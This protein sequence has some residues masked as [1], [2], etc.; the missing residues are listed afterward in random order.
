[1]ARYGVSKPLWLNE[2]SLGCP[3]FYAHCLPPTASFYQ[4]QADFVPRMIA[5]SLSAGAGQ[6][7][8]YTLNSNGWRYSSLLDPD[9]VPRPS[10]TAYQALIAQV[11]LTPLPAE[12]VT[13]D[14]YVEGYRFHTSATTVVDV[15][16]TMAPGWSPVTV[17]LPQSS[18][19]RAVRQD[20]SPLS[21]T[22]SDGNARLSVGFSA[23]YIHRRP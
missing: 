16:W 19:I 10:F 7:I 15:L 20:G 13:Y 17:T 12:P 22:I 4:A 11:G 8:W 21:P 6:I 9:A 3:E 5:R 1:M 18:F 14:P 23:I 2:T